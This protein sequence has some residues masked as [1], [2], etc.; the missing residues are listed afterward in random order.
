[1]L[2]LST[3]HIKLGSVY[4]ARGESAPALDAYRTALR[5]RETLLETQPDNVEVVEK[6]LDVQNELAELQ[7]QLGDDAERDPDLPRRRSR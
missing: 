1:M 7:R 4:L 2:A 5:L 6:V 3:S